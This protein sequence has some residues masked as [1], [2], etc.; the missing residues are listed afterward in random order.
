VHQFYSL[1]AL[2]L[3]NFHILGSFLPS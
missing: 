3:E 1:E 2:V